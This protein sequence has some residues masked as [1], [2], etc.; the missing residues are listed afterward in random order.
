M[1]IRPPWSRRRCTQP[2]T[3]ALGVGAVGDQLAPAPD[4]AVLVRRGRCFTDCRS[5]RRIV[6]ITSPSLQLVLLAATP[7]PSAWPP[8]SLDDRNVPGAEP[9]RVPA[10]VP[11][12]SAPRARAAPAGPRGAPR[13]SA[14]TPSRSLAIADH[15]DVQVDEAQA[16]S[17]ARR[18]PAG[19]ARPPPPS[20]RPASADR[21]AARSG[22]R[23]A[24]R[25]RR[26]TARR[27]RRSRTRTPCA[28]SS[29]GRAPASG[30]AR[31]ADPA[32]SSSAR[33][34]AK[35]SASSRIEPVE[36]RRARPAS[37]RCVPGS[38]GVERSQRIQIDPSRTS[39]GELLLVGAQVTPSAPRGTRRGSAGVPRL[40][41]RSRTALDPERLEQLSQAATISSA[42]VS[43]ARQPIASAPTCQNW[44]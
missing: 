29:R 1:K 31:S 16:R 26:R 15:G 6:G 17:V 18:R 23:S 4:V 44:R 11:S 43:G 27:A 38:L 12:A 14:R 20:P 41:S 34:R 40:E 8:F 36:Q 37:P 21:R 7:C 32:S 9:V 19:S 22:R 28:C 35:C 39:A 30:R 2:A 33:T 10:A 42:S 24:R 3:R 13:A 25:R 5:A